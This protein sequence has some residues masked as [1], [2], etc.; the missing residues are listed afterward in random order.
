MENQLDSLGE[1]LNT[2]AHYEVELMLHQDDLVFDK[3]RNKLLSFA[4]GSRKNIEYMGP[5]KEQ[6]KRSVLNLSYAIESK[7][8]HINDYISLT[9]T[10]NI[11]QKYPFEL[12]ISNHFDEMFPDH[13]GDRYYY[14]EPDRYRKDKEN[15]QNER[16]NGVFWINA[17]YLQLDV[18]GKYPYY[19]LGTIKDVL[20]YNAIFRNWNSSNKTQ[21]DLDQYLATNFH[22]D[23]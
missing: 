16:S 2:I 23:N 1:N 20:K 22:S 13:C 12:R 6:E 3:H 19:L 5:Y 11:H 10:D 17:E 8:S 9:Y 18:R 4:S 14:I 7:Y 21:K 15:Y